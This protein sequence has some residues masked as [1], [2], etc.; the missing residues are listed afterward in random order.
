MFDMIAR[1]RGAGGGGGAGHTRDKGLGTRE[2]RV[3]GRSGARKV[4]VVAGF[5]GS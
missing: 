4:A 5:E 2:P 1:V 3:A